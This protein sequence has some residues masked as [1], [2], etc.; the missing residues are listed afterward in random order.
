MQPCAFFFK[1][2]ARA[3]TH[4]CSLSMCFSCVE[5]HF[6]CQSN[7]LACLTRQVQQH[8]SSECNFRR[9]LETVNY[10]SESCNYNNSVDVASCRLHLF[11]STKQDVTKIGNLLYCVARSPEFLKYLLNFHIYQST[12][13]FPIMS[14]R[15]QRSIAH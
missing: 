11:L 3:H 13:L 12:Q 6:L 7:A 5:A 15:F 2:R 1:A 8:K 14:L 9:A 10:V 4:K